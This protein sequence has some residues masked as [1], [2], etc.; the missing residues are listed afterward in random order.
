ME[1]FIPGFD[2]HI[3][4]D[5]PQRE[6]EGPGKISGQIGLGVIIVQVPLVSFYSH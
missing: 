2:G 5:I 1:F 6:N 3:L 4:I